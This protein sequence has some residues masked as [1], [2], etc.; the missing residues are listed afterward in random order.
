MLFASFTKKQQAR[1]DFWLIFC[2]YWRYAIA[3]YLYSK[4]SYFHMNTNIRIV[5]TIRPNTN[6][7]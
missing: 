6:M 1:C 7:K 2:K 5:A 4:Y 3:K